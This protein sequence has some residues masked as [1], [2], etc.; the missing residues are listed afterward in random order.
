MMNIP[1]QTEYWVRNAK[2]DF[3]VGSNLI[4]AGKTRHGLFFVHLAMEKMLKACVCKNQNKTP[5]K[6]HN[7]INLYRLAGLEANTERQDA[8]GALNRFCIEGRYPEEWPV[9]SDKKESQRYLIMAEQL[10]EWLKKQL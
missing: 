4:K 10:I 7:L 3:E 1:K 2:E 6:I 8:L 9:I 5:P